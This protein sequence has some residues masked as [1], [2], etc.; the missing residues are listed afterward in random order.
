MMNQCYCPYCRS[1]VSAG[2]GACRRCGR[3]LTWTPVAAGHQA[4]GGH[5]GDDIQA[6]AGK[7]WLWPLLALVV[8]VV[9]VGAGVYFLMRMLEKPPVAPAVQNPAADVQEGLIIPDTRVPVI[10]NIEVND[11]S[12][13]SVEIKWTTDEPSTSQVL[14]RAGDGPMSGTDEKDAMVNQH[15]VGLAGLKDKQMYYFKVRSADQYGNEAISV[16]DSFDIGLSQGVAAVSVKGGSENGGSMKTEE[17]QPGVFRTVISG[18]VVNTG[19]VSLRSR[20]IEVWIKI[21]VA[22]KAGTS[23]VKA[24]IDPV[25]DTLNPLAEIGFRA[26]VPE[27]TDPK[28]T[29]TCRINDP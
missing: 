2:E 5:D 17:P 29:V 23:D 13:N 11:L 19:E 15:T 18:R 12:Y 25:P 9:L 21:T 10:S 24:D 16:E 6:D 14:W 26:V 8:I 4:E 3:S 27:R 28:Y 7:S 22:G 20:N 1:P